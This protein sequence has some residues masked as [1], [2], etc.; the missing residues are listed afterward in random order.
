MQSIG[1]SLKGAISKFRKLGQ[2]C[3]CSLIFVKLARSNM[4][5]FDLDVSA[6]SRPGRIRKT[7]MPLKKQYV[8][9]PGYRKSPMH[10]GMEPNSNAPKTQI[11]TC[12]SEMLIIVCL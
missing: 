7:S 5:V 4:L 8:S 10:V 2:F 9:E 12:M 1:I 6:Q 11:H 3:N